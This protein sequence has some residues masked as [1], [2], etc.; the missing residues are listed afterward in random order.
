MNS[1][2][3]A[4]IQYTEQTTAVYLPVAKSAGNKKW[5][6]EKLMKAKNDR[7]QYS[8][9]ETEYNALIDKVA[10]NALEEGA[11]QGIAAALFAAEM[12]L[13]W[14]ETR[15]KRFYSAIEDVFNMPDILG[16]SATGHGAIERIRDMYGID[17]ENIEVK[18]EVGIEDT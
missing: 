11:K 9:S 14:K 13:G 5:K 7:Y 4:V 1:G 18:T 6:M 10:K 8:I 15:L 17:I 2:Q 12:S 3:F 16:V